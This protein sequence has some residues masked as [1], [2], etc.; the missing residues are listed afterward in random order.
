MKVIKDILFKLRHRSCL[1]SRWQNEGMIQLCVGY[2]NQIVE[3]IEK[4]ALSV[5]SV[6]GYLRHIPREKETYGYT[7]EVYSTASKC[8]EILFQYSQKKGYISKNM[9]I[10]DFLYKDWYHQ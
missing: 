3:E 8:F 5:H 1:A 9:T 7:K 6:W 2:Y 4:D 10:D